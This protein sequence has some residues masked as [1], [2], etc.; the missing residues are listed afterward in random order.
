GLAALRACFEIVLQGRPRPERQ[1]VER[2]LAES[3][4]P[5]TERAREIFWRLLAMDLLDDPE[6]V[7]YAEVG[8]DRVALVRDASA[9]RWH[10][11]VVGARVRA[12]VSPYSDPA[13]AMRAWLEHVQT[14]APRQ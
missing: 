11:G 12:E 5:D 13:E 2:L 3:P 14:M 6:R 9:A 8:L 1:P 7:A 10:V 4:V